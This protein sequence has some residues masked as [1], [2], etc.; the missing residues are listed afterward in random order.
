MKRFFSL[1]FI[2]AFLGSSALACDSWYTGDYVQTVKCK[3]YI[4]LREEPSASARVL[5][6][7]PLDGISVYLCHHDDIFAKVLYNG[8]IGYVMQGYLKNLFTVCEHC[9]PKNLND[10]ELYN[11]QLF[12]TNFTEQG[13]LHPTGVLH[14]E[15]MT[16]AEL[17]DFAVEHIWYNRQDKLE[18]GE[19][20]NENNVRLDK[21]HIPEV[22]LKYFNRMPEFFVSARYDIDGDYVCWQETGGHLPCGFAIVNSVH[23]LGSG[24]YRVSF[25]VYG[26]GMEWDEEV[27]SMNERSLVHEMP[28][29]CSS[30]RPY[31]N[32]VINVNGGSLMDRSTWTLERL[33]MDWTWKSM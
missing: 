25:C 9:I 1:L 14:G 29:Y 12:I 24:R 16:A 19:Y 4:S 3:E 31:G 22:C 27:Y 20:K 32:A 5:D 11:L 28:Q 7:I 33:A 13:M 10:E 8:Q 2:L 23:D 30:V 18:W 15:S 17:V 26:Q 6:H 21:Q